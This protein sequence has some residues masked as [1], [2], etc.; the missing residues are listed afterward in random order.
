M[1]TIND[2]LGYEAPQVEIVEVCVEQGFAT[3]GGGNFENPENGSISG[4]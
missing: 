2:L 1:K 3:S 4:W